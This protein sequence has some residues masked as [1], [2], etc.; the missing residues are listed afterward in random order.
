M[1]FFTKK[2][3]KIWIWKAVCRRSRKLVGWYIGDRSEG[4]LEKFYEQI[5]DWPIKTFYADKYAVYPAVLP[6]NDLVQSKAETNNVERNNSTQRHWLARFKRRS[7][8]INRSINMMEASMRL[9]ARFRVNGNI[10]EL[11]SILR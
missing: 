11:L 1:P 10:N 6:Y 3:Q 9:F 2:K 4:S 8:V 7:I 5:M